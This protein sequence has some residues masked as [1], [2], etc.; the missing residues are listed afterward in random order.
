MKVTLNIC[1]IE[2]QYVSLNEIHTN[3]SIVK[4]V[5]VIKHT[6]LTKGIFDLGTLGLLLQKLWYSNTIFF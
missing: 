6:C 4:C 3:T 1:I 2:L 5:H